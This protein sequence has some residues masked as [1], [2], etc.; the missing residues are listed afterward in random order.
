[1]SCGYAYGEDST[2]YKRIKFP[3]YGIYGNTLRVIADST[4][5]NGYLIFEINKSGDRLSSFHENY[6]I[7]RLFAIRNL[8]DFGKDSSYLLFNVPFVYFIYTTND[9]T[10]MYQ[11]GEAKHNFVIFKQLFENY[12]NFARTSKK[13]NVP[14]LWH[15]MT[16]KLF[17][18]NR[19]SFMTDNKTDSLGYFI[20]KCSFETILLS[21][22]YYKKSYYEKNNVGNFLL[23]ISKLKLMDP[24][25]T[26]KLEKYG[27]KTNQWSP[28]NMFNEE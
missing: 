12:E 4:T 15:S 7:T 16:T 23:P 14:F 18:N 9:T 5:F 24:M 6:D 8:E 17:D 28:K 1:M 22:T 2:Y 26:N 20:F 27:F 19:L 25:S 3:D 10:F 11:N 21:Y 13:K